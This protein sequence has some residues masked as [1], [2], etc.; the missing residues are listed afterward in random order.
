M[1]IS[2]FVIDAERTFADALSV[3]LEAEED[4]DIVMSL[5]P[6]A[7]APSLILG[8]H[9]DV[10]LLDAD[11]PDNAAVNLCEEL[12][13]R[14]EAPRV[15]MM[16]S[17][18]EAARIADAVRA[19]TA[20]WVRKDES[21]N[22]L[23]HVMRGVVEGETWLPRAEM[24]AVLRLLLEDRER[25]RESD[26]LLAALTPREREILSCLA[27]GAGRH[28]VAERLHLSANTVRTHLQNLMAKLGVHSTLEAVALTRAQ[29]S[30]SST[31]ES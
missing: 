1:G 22:H 11:L 23:L 21:L 24:G 4:I 18:S 25:Q 20:A 12:T 6:K 30:V 15:V 2:V 28:D 29:L 14:S 27:D 5:H 8:R 10:V 3:R 7:P 17:G 31:S 16:S 26:R 19:G 13:G 9:A